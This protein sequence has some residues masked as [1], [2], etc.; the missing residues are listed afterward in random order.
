MEG[1]DVRPP[2]PGASAKADEEARVAAQ[3]P[4]PG[5][6]SEDV[7]AEEVKSKE[8]KVE[9]V[10]EEVA[11]EEDVKSSTSSDKKDV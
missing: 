10:V 8:P 5:V 1:R 11:R 9:S 6:K 4:V 7:K 2:R 3:A